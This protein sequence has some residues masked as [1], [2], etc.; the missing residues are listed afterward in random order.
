MFII[1]RITIEALDI[2]KK[3]ELCLSSCIHVN[4]VHLKNCL[5]KENCVHLLWRLV[6]LVFN[7]FVLYLR[8]FL[9][10]LWV[11]KKCEAKALK[12]SVNGTLHG[13][14][15]LCLSRFYYF[16]PLSCE[17]FVWYAQF[18]GVVYEMLIKKLSTHL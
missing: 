16:N 4:L 14:H 15:S 18:W 11:Y 1:T 5:T 7:G 6:I 9:Y 3:S 10:I 12:A 13:K 17:S 8:I 2:I